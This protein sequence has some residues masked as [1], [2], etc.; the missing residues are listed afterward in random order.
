MKLM[1]IRNRDKDDEFKYKSLSV[2]MQKWAQ[3]VNISPTGLKIIAGKHGHLGIG[4]ARATT[5]E[6]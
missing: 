4:R 6:I 1:L 2:T 5:C 3:K